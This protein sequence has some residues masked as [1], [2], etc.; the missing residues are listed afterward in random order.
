MHD[1]LGVCRMGSSVQASPVHLK[2]GI[3]QVV[4]IAEQTL[5]LPLCVPPRNFVSGIGNLGLA[6]RRA[7]ARK[8]IDP[9]QSEL[10]AWLIRLRLG[11][12]DFADGSARVEHPHEQP[13][14]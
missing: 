1:A 10:L 11:V 5:K 14:E 6:Q 9:K 13:K 12:F 4:A 8:G 7:E 2:N 3:L